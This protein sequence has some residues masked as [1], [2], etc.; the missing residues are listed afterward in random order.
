MV[1]NNNFNYLTRTNINLIKLKNYKFISW[2]FLQ[3][4]IVKINRKNTQHYRSIV[5]SIYTRM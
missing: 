5:V 1:T 3:D 2:L 4:N